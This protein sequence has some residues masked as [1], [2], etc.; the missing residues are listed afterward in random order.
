[1]AVVLSPEKAS[2]GFSNSSGASLTLTNV[3]VLP[4]TGQPGNYTYSSVVSSD[5][6]TGPVTVAVLE[7]S[8]QDAQGNIGP[9]HDVTSDTTINLVDDSHFNIGP[10]QSTQQP[11]A[12]YL[13]PVVI[14]ALII[15]ALIL[16]LV[17]RRSKKNTKS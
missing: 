4:V 17:R 10:V 12:N 11:S 14:G 3:T 16:L 2:F 9:P 15:L 7:G 8:L 13:V 1:M 6:P 5:F